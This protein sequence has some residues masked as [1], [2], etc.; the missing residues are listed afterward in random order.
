MTEPQARRVISIVLVCI[1]V[2]AIALECAIR[3]L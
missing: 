1:A 2:V 3:G